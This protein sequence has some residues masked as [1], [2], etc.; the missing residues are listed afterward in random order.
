M[1]ESSAGQPQLKGA[2]W[3]KRPALPAEFVTRFT[4]RTT[5][6]RVEASRSQVWKINPAH[7]ANGS[8]AGMNAYLFFGTLLL[9][10]GVYSRGMHGTTGRTGPAISPDSYRRASRNTSHPFAMKSSPDPII[11]ILDWLWL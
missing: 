4:S 11:I 9:V 7:Y 1:C 10:F 2:N 5:R 6:S 3:A 8:P